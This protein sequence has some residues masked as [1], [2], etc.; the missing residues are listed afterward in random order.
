VDGDAQFARRLAESGCLVLAPVL[1]NRDARWS[2][3]Q[4][5]G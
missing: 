5:F 1:I 3:A 2:A 4:T